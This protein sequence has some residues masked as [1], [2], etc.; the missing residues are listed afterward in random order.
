[1]MNTFITTSLQGDCHIDLNR[2]L[3]WDASS[4]QFSFDKG[5]PY[6]AEL[7]GTLVGVQA[8]VENGG[9]E[10]SAYFFYPETLL[11][12]HMGHFLDHS[13]AAALTHTHA[14]GT[15]V[16][17]GVLCKSPLALAALEGVTLDSKPGGDVTHAS[18]RSDSAFAN[19]KTA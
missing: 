13:V 6:G 10:T 8:Q 18:M 2:A 16:Q 7:E 3:A 5:L 12:F 19:I 4:A 17:L 15:T 9:H 1:W 14:I 11:P